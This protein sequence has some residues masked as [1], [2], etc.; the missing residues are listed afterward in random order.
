MA[1]AI[2]PARGGSK[3]LP[4][5]NVALLAGRPLITYTI[6]SAFGSGLFTRVIVSTEDPEIAAVAA[7]AG[8]QVDARPAALASDTAGVVDVCCDLLG[9]LSES[10]ATFCCLYAT[11]A[12]R[13]PDDIRAAR[14][15][16]DPGRCDFVMAVTEYAKTPLQALAETGDGRLRLMWPDLVDLPREK[17]PRLWVDNGS[18]YWCTTGAFLDARTFYGPNLR[19]YPMPRAR[20]VDVDTPDDLEL[21]AYHHAR[22]SRS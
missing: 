20:S 3:R 13:R 9:R 11:A 21:L 8:A 16:L 1:V 10:A 18:T 4:R 2:I 15:L 17:R 14:E 7:Q 22:E 5:K 12:L 19:G 6:E